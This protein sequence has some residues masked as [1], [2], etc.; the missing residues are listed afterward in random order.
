MQSIFSLTQMEPS[1]PFNPAVIELGRRLV[2]ALASEGHDDVLSKWMAHYIASL[3]TE[4]ER[5]EPG[6]HRAEAGRACMEGVLRL[7]THRRMLPNGSRPLENAESALNTLTKLDPTIAENFYFRL[8]ERRDESDTAE[9]VKW[10]R[11]AEAVDQAART[12]IRFCLGQA[13][14]KEESGLS[15]WV[16]LT[17]SLEAPSEWDVLLVSSLVEVS[18]DSEPEKLARRNE[19]KAR[20]LSEKLASLIPVLQALQK[21]LD[22]ALPDGAP[23]PSSEMP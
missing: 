11:S 5:A 22:G 23:S 6:P 8:H 20:D 1:Q 7:W 10:L 21:D 9:G 3:M 12:L 17:K 16:E 2:D 4:A 18:K 13:I 14:A 15:E 19:A